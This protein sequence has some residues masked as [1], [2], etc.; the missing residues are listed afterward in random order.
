MSFRQ[1]LNSKDFVI[2]AEVPLTPE[3]SRESLLADAELLADSVDGILLTDN[4]YGQPHMVPSAAAGILLVGG[5][6]PILQLS[7]RN[8]NRIALIGEL[9]GARALG[10]DSLMLVRG[11]V[12]PDAYKPRPKPVMDLDAKE[13]IAMAQTMNEDEKLSS[14]QDFLLAAAATV[15]DPTPDWHPDELISK[16]DVGTQL[17]FTQL[18]FD[19]DLLRRYMEFLVSHQLVRRFSVIVSIAPVFSADLAIWL[20]EN[21]RRAIVPDSLVERLKA[22]DDREAGID[23]CAD[24]IAEASTIPG[25][26]GV[27]FSLGEDVKAVPEIVRRSGIKK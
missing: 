8:R 23:A 10:V 12:V 6:S 3:S 7:C 21:R 4:Q 18:C 26:S 9:L 13:L 15:H 24:L 22:A 25:V 14:A 19:I 17:V 20:R 11:S 16:A 1:A 2:T 27:N 5:H